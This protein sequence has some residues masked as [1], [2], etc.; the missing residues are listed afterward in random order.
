[1]AFKSTTLDIDGNRIEAAS[2]ED[3]SSGVT[4]SLADPTQNAGD[5][6]GD[7]YANIE[8]ASIEGLVG[9]NGDDLLIGDGQANA[10]QGGDGNDT[11]EGAIGADTL[12]GGNGNDFVS[13]A[14][15]KEAVIADILAG[16]LAGEA[17]GDV[18][19]SIEGLI[20][21]RFNDT[22]YGAGLGPV[23]GIVEAEIF[24]IPARSDA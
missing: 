15:A 11:L 7:I 12:D 22:L 21:S 5:A 6:V 18:Y 4:A 19:T 9:S 20:G 8:D 1:M 13:Y 2:Y 24:R 3:F 10:L 17:E 23:D 16:G 14:N